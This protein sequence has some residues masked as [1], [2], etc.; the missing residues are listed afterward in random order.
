MQRYFIKNEMIEDDIIKLSNEQ[1]HHINKVMRM[2]EKDLIYCI[3]SVG[4]IYLCEIENS[5]IPEV[6]IKS[7]SNKNYELDVNINL[8]YG[9][10]KN[11]KFEFVLQKATE[12]GVKAIFP[13]IANR[14]Q[15]KYIRE[16]FIKKYNRYQKIIMEAGEQSYRNK[17]PSL[18]ALTEFNQLVI[19]EADIKIIA[20][21][22]NSKN[23]ELSNLK[24]VLADLKAGITV[25]I[26]VGPE[27]GF[28]QQEVEYFNS[29]GYISCSL[30][31]RIL[32]TET[33]PLYLLSVIG[34]LREFEY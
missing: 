16:S 13:F 25:N 32:R 6:L 8:I 2:K 17:L 26:I 19:P 28:E 21:E 7:V 9:F 23:G 31:K 3:D 15:S 4:L 14:S 20:Y 24:K 12:L 11:D 33:A 5:K 1:W 29:L 34:Y 30:G 22:E 27:G 18:K 10:P